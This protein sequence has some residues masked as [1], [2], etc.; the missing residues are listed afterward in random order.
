MKKR[1]FVGI[2]IS[3]KMLVFIKSW[4]KKNPWL[5]EQDFRL[6]KPEN[7]HLTIIPPW[8]EENVDNV[9]LKVED[10]LKNSELKPFK[11]TFDNIST[12]PNTKNSRLIWIKGRPNPD[13]LR[14]KSFL[15]KSLG[16]SS[17]SKKFVPHI[18]IARF[19]EIKD[20]KELYNRVSIEE[21]ICSF[22]IFES[23]LSSKGSSYKLIKDFE[24]KC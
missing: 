16:F 5:Y 22:S 12:G 18:T 13:I 1:I 4:I 7:L 14:I 11:I 2:K 20:I 23:R 10:R 21:N 8:Y 19:R 17:V 15:E 3:E 24:F 6:I 9:I